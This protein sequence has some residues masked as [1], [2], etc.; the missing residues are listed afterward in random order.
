MLDVSMIVVACFDN[1]L[2]STA[3]FSPRRV[4]AE[5]ACR[6][7]SLICN[8]CIPH[9]YEV[10]TVERIKVEKVLGELLATRSP[11]F[12]PQVTPKLAADALEYAA[13]YN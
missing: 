9:S 4:N 10:P 6:A 7:A 3:I 1:L 5:E 12:Y 13:Y 11:A 2:R 8:G